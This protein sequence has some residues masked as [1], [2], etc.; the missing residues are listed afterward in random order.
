[1]ATLKEIQLAAAN[2]KLQREAVNAIS[3][4]QGDLQQQEQ[5]QPEQVKKDENVRYFCKIAGHRFIFEDGTEAFFNYG[6]LD[7]GPK[8]YPTT[9]RQ[10]QKELNAILGR[11]T[12]IFIPEVPPEVEPVVAQ[13]AKSEAEIVAGEQK[14]L[15]GANAKVSQEIATGGTNGAPTDVNQSTVDPALREAMMGTLPVGMAPSI[16]G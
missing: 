7:V 3:N 11:Q 15:A 14:L 1:M 5:K 10:Y 13:N 9:W 2:A 6:R 12:T 8:S 4:S 16:S